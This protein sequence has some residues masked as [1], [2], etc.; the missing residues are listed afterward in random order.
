MAGT[1]VADDIQHSTA[2]SVGTEYVVDGST[3][4][5]VNLD[6]IGTVAVRDDLNVSSITDNATGIYTV[7]F[8][9]SMSDA[10]YCVT[11]SISYDVNDSSNAFGQIN[12]SNN[13]ST[14]SVQVKSANSSGVGFDCQLMCASVLSGG[15]A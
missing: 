6:G 8:S 9:N 3:K 7:N 10:N 14:S 13:V 5:W 15:L 11:V 2:G 4:M 1:I 12:G